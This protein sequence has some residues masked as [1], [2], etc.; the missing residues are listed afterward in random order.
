[1]SMWG[2]G[3]SRMNRGFTLIELTVILALSG[4]VA[5]LV[6]PR[7]IE[8]IFSGGM[9]STIREVSLVIES[10]RSESSMTRRPHRLYFDLKKGTYWPAVM[11]G[12]G[13]FV[14]ISTAV[15][16]ERHLPKGISF[17]DIVSPRDGK[18]REGEASM[19]FLPSGVTEEMTIHLEGDEGEVYTLMVMPL[20][21]RMRI[22]DRYVEAIK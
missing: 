2:I 9:K 7:F 13:E 22:Y 6:V 4:L 12:S 18:I 11:E 1:M 17:R 15:L 8:G 3:K 10:V 20:T 19:N 21:G 16:S 14:R 5:I